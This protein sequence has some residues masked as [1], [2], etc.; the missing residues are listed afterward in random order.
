[1]RIWRCFWVFTTVAVCSLLE[2]QIISHDNITDLSS[3]TKTISQ[4]QLQLFELSVNADDG[5][6]I[7]VDNEELVF[8]S[9]NICTWPQGVSDVL[10]DDAAVTP[11]TDTFNHSTELA[12]YYSLDE[13]LKS[14]VLLGRRL[15][16][17][18]GHFGALTEVPKNLLSTRIYIAVQ[19]PQNLN[20]LAQWT[21]SFAASFDTI[22]YQ[23]DNLL[24]G[25][26]VDT[27]QNS[28]LVVTGNLTYSQGSGSKND[29]QILVPRLGKVDSLQ[30]TLHVFNWDQKAYLDGYLR[31]WCAVSRGPTLVDPKSI[32]TNA[33]QRNGQYEQQFIVQGLNAS[34]RYVAYILASYDGVSSDGQP[35][36]GRFVYAPFEI[37]T[38]PDAACDLVF[39]LDFCKDVTYAVPAR[40][41]TSRADLGKMYDSYAQEQYVNFS[42]ALQQVPCHASPELAYLPVRTCQDCARTY[43]EWLCS[44]TF[45]R[46][47]SIPRGSG[48]VWRDVNALRSL[49][50]NEVIQPSLG[51]YE[52][53]PCIDICERLVRDCPSLFQFQCPSRKVLGGQ[54]YALWNSSSRD[55]TCNWLGAVIKSGAVRLTAAWAVMQWGLWVV[56]WWIV[57]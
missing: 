2:H 9:G 4:G 42:K 28:A 44:V 30:Y 48:Y 49:L 19:A 22:S 37:M 10:G 47:S 20:A 7:G 5:D 16:F 25:S 23:W 50:V 17:E 56:V 29:R 12:V 46:C 14:D 54:L 24:W 38:Q 11:N 15:F 41:G 45:P 57:A 55:P 32:L 53:L 18:S 27:T 39:G 43:K 35:T 13:S 26:V 34:T 1:M 6:N 33:V 36:F 40:Q 21:Y 52:L 3:I 31:S 51:Y 8:L